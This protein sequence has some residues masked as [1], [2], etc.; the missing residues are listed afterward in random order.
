MKEICGYKGLDG[1]FYEKKVDCEKADLK[2][3]IEILERKL[4]NFKVILSDYLFKDYD[5]YKFHRY[6]VTSVSKYVLD[7]IAQ[8][9]LRD[10]EMFISIIKQKDKLKDDLDA[11]NKTFKE[12]YDKPWWLKIIWWK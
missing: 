7:N 1:E 5:T 8:L 12:E 4:N 2:Y 3:R 10:S 6:D 9:V 11:L